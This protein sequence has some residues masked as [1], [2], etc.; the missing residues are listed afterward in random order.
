M[1]VLCEL[2]LGSIVVGAA[3]F[4]EVRSALFGL[5]LSN[6]VEVLVS[7]D[8]YEAIVRRYQADGEPDDRVRWD[9]AVLDILRPDRPHEWRYLV[10]SLGY[11]IASGEGAGTRW[12]RHAL[13][14][15]Q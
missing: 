13:T 9:D 11:Q 7:R 1:L 5:S 6:G 10:R 14:V 2:I 8:T 4:H 12:Q 15:R 3:I